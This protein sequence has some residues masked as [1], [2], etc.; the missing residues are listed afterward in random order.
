MKRQGRNARLDEALGMKHRGHHKQSLK[1]R[2]DESRAMSEADEK[3][4]HHHMAM[5]HHEHM[6][7]HHR[8]KYHQTMKDRRHEAEGMRRYDK[9]RK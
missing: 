4:Y 5:A 6:H 9:K 7:D 1:D 2:R 3:R 8:K